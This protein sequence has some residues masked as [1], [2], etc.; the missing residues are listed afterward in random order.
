MVFLVSSAALAGSS[1]SAVSAGHSSGATTV[2]ADTE[3]AS[4]AGGASSGAPSGT[5]VSHIVIAGE[6]ATVAHLPPHAPFSDA[7]LRKLHRAG[8][9]ARKQDQVTYW[10]RRLRWTAQGWMNDCFD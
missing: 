7:Q 1:T 9:Y 10:C 2:R 3:G 8:Y 4:R 5:P 6:Q